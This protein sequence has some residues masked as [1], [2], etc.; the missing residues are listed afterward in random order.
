MHWSHRQWCSNTHTVVLRRTR[1]SRVTRYDDFGQYDYIELQIRITGLNCTNRLFI[2][3]RAH[4]VFDFHQIVDGL[5]EVELGGSRYAFT[6]LHKYQRN[7]RRIQHWHDEEGH[8]PGL[9]IEG[10]ALRPACASS[11]RS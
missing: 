2:S 8:R 5:K 4:L 9:F 3:D 6:P 11:L 1:C 7:T 10:V